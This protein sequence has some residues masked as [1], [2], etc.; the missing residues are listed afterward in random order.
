MLEAHNM[1]LD[2]WVVAGGRPRVPGEPLNTPI[3]AVSNFRRGGDLSYARGDGTPTIA[4]F[5]ELVGGM[6]GGIATTFSSGIAAAAAVYATLSTGAVVVLPKGGYHGVEELAEDG[7]TKG[8]WTT[9]LIDLADTDAW[10]DAVGRAD[11]IWLESPS[12]PMLT[13]VDLAPICTA[14][15]KP[16]NIIAVDNT[17]ATSFNQR[18]LE[19]GADVVMHSA[20]KFIGGHSDL[21]AGALVTNREELAAEFRT[22]RKVTGALPG[23]LEAYLA[24][25][26]ARTMAVR[27]ERGQASAAVLAE[28]LAASPHVD[29]V[30]YP[31]LA[32]DPYHEVAKRVLDGFGAVISI[33]VVGGGPAADAVCD[34]I[35]LISHATSLGGVESTMERRALGPDGLIRLSVGCEN[36]EDLWSDLAQA[37][38]PG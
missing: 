29:V 24:V 35:E 36:V 3:T 19:F 7:A 17:F 38:D 34:R 37:L 11:L 22:T 33:D 14:N 23:A 25:R 15:R 18:P 20:S 6:E 13:V 12:N 5:E 28:R 31:G 4:A 21:V 26:G 2:S 9:E 27:L 8:R 32:S 16:G 10:I 30:R 1:G